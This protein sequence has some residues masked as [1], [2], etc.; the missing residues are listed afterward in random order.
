M[1]KNNSGSVSFPGGDGEPVVIAKEDFVSEQHLPLGE[2]QAV[3]EPKQIEANGDDSHVDGDGGS[4]D[5]G[6][7][8]SSAGISSS[9]SATRKP[10]TNENSSKKTSSR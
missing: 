10:N 4:H 1:P 3:D 8:G 2:P 5:S 7:D 6:G 9:P